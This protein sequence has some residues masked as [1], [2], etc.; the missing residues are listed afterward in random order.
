MAINGYFG[1]KGASIRGRGRG[2]PLRAGQGRRSLAGRAAAHNAH[3]FCEFHTRSR[4]ASGCFFP[5]LK[6]KGTAGSHRST[7][8]AAV[9]S[10]PA[11]SPADYNSQHAPLS[12]GVPPS[13]SMQIQRG[14]AA[15]HRAGAGG[16]RAVTWREASFLC[17][18]LFPSS[19]A[20]LCAPRVGP[21]RGRRAQ[22]RTAPRPPASC[23]RPPGLFPAPSLPFCPASGRGRGEARPGRGA[24][25]SARP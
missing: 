24:A 14:A 19:A 25:G 3:L 9:P 6:A 10:R 13:F 23:G 1:R 18:P 11:P 22:V 16:A 4:L 8:P 15:N 21:P 2:Q 7:V 17:A 12:G 20:I 5:P